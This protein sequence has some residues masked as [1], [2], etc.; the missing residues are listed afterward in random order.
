MERIIPLNKRIVV[1]QEAK[2]EVSKGGIVIPQTTHQKAP[3]KGTVV[4]IED[5]SEINLK[6]GDVV[7]F[8]K[9]AGTE[10]VAPGQAGQKD[11]HLLLMKEEDILAK[12]EVRND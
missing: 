9:Y 2:Q 5:N 10:I 12:I 4:A 1:E 6:V 8:S 7:L 11:I 3:T